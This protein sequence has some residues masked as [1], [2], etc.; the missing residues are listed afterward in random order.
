MPR[1]LAW[2]AGRA[3]C[4]RTGLTGIAG[5]FDLIV[6]NPPY[7]PLGDIAGLAPDV[8]EFDPPRALDGGPDGLEAYRRIAFGAGDHLAPNFSTSFWRSGRDRK[9]RLTILERGRGFA[10]ESRHFD[11]SRHVRCLAFRP[12]LKLRLV[13][14]MS[15]KTIGNRFLLQ[16]TVRV[17][18]SFCPCDGVGRHVGKK[19]IG[20][21]FHTSRFFAVGDGVSDRGNICGRGLRP[22]PS[23]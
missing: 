17:G 8:R 20:H 16:L 15:K 2:R 19:T 7:V 13:D 6:S 11:L 21:K 14:T 3:L 22:Q 9:T 23:Y 1:P 12:G 5:R 4:R 10:Q 18:N